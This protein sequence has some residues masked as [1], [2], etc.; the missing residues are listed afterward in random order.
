MPG[1]K[2]QVLSNAIDILLNQG[3]L[4]EELDGTRLYGEAL[5][6]DDALKADC[7]V[8]QLSNET[9]NGQ[10]TVYQVFNGIELYYNDMH[11]AYCNQDQVTAKNIIE[12]NHCY[13]GRYECSFGEN[14]CCYLSA[15]DLSIGSP[16]HMKHIQILT[17]V[18]LHII[19]SSSYLPALS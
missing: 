1:M 15:G 12:I 2:R 19:G 4:P 17:F 5:E 6:E 10:I 16:I 9:G 14:S 3:N 7:R 11:M 13:I 18:R 8:Y